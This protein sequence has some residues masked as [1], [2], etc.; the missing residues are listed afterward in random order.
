MDLGKRYLLFWYNGYYPRGGME[1]CVT[2]FDE[3]NELEIKPHIIPNTNYTIW[4]N[5]SSQHYVSNMTERTAEIFHIYDQ[6][7]RKMI[8]Q[9][10]FVITV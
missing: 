7:D 10:E 5:S 8:T 9:D 6:K 3:L 1:D 4:K 2:T